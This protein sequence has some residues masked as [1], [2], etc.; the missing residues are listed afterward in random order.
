MFFAHIRQDGKTQTV[1]EH[2]DGT[3]AR[4]AEFAARFG[5]EP[6]GRLLGY[7]HDIGKC[8]EA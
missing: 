5:E 6:R 4:C 8:S 7:A 2:L 1:E 3:A